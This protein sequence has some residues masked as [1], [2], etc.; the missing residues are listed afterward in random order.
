MPMSQNSGQIWRTFGIVCVVSISALII[1]GAFLPKLPD[2]RSFVAVSV[3]DIRVTD[4]D[5]IRF[6]N[7]PYRLVG[8]DAPETNKKAK[9]DSERALAD[10]A[11]VRL[12]ELISSG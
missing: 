2:S 4:G 12:Q 9:C 5:T 10:R 1:V 11:A 6:K 8:F 7:T 3:T